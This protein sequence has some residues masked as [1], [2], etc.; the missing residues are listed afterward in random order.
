MQF[1]KQLISCAVLHNFWFAYNIYDNSNVTQHFWIYLFIYIF[2][3]F[4]KLLHNAVRLM[5][6]FV[7]VVAFLFAALALEIYQCLQHFKG[8]CMKS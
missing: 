8:K 5:M 2:C 1:L 4:L 3:Q 7:K 6:V